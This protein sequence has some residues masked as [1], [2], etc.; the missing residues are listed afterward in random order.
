MWLVPCGSHHVAR[1]C[2]RILHKIEAER[3]SLAAYTVSLSQNVCQVRRGASFDDPR[4]FM[5][6]YLTM[7]KTYSLIKIIFYVRKGFPFIFTF[8]VYISTQSN[9]KK[10]SNIR[11]YFMWER[12]GS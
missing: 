1:L 8:K 11:V 2:R 7:N 6:S 12:D 3:M 9:V 10:Y 5:T 4:K